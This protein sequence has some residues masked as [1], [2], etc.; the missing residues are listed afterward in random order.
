[1]KLEVAPS[2]RIVIVFNGA[3]YPMHKPKLGALRVLEAK[4]AQAKESGQGAISVIADHLVA[5]GLPAEVVEELDDDQAEA[6]MKA[7]S[8]SKKN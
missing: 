2:A 6:V 4:I 3:E 8:A 7:L 1:M 5:C